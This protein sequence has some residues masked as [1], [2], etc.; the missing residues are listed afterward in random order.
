M[1]VPCCSGLTQIVLKAI[2]KNKIAM[3]FEDVTIDLH[4]NISRTETMQS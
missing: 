4:G 1:E 3:S 2:V